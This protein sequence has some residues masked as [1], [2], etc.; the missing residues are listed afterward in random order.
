M[1]SPSS[2]ALATLR[3]DLAGSFE[4]YGLD[5]AAQKFIAL[6]VLPVIEVQKAAGKFGRIKLAE[7]LQA[8]DSLRAPGAGYSRGDWKFETS[9]FSTDEHGLEEPVDDREAELY[10]LYFSAEVVS[11]ARARNGVM[12]N[13]EL[14]ASALLFNSTTWTGA[15]LTTAI[16]NEWDDAPNAKPRADVKAAMIKVWDGSGMWPDTLIIN[17]LVF[18]HLKDVAEIIDRLKYAGFTDP[19]PEFINEVALAQALGIARVVV[20]GAPQNTAKEGQAAVI[21]PA[22]SNEYAMVAKIAA[23]GDIREPCVGRTFHW[24]QDGST[25][26]G[27]MESYRDEPKRSNIIRVRHDVDEIV[28]YKEAAHLISNVTT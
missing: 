12:L 8:R 20:G 4:E 6:D 16:T 19:R 18:E 5:V 25:I 9:S 14:R 13:A 15:G 11:A 7:L 2:A 3:P 1:P 26:G 17:R 24:A 27:T 23:S 10:N 22:W 21:A 28:L